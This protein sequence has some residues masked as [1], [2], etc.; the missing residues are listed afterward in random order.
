MQIIIMTGKVDMLPVGD[1][2]D[3][4]V[5]LSLCKVE[6]GPCGHVALLKCA[7]LHRGR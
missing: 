6:Y 2:P 7:K 3:L 4:G 5:H 1:E